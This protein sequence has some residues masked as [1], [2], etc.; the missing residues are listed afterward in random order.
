MSA[1]TLGMIAAFAW[2]LHDICVRYLSQKTPL[3][4]SLLTVLVVALGFE[5]GLMVVTKSTFT[6]PSEAFWI[7]VVSG[8]FLSLPVLGFTPHFIVAL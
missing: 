6:L 8:F 2:A 4:A 3:M 7:S 5:I 1:L